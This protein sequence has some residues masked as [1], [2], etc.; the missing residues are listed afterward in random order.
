MNALYQMRYHGVAGA[1]H[2][3]I[4]IGKGQV[5]GVDITGAR[6]IGSYSDNGT[7]LDGTVTLTSSGAELVTG[8]RMAPGSKIPITFNFPANFGNGQFQTVTV[9]NASVQVAFDKI[10]DIP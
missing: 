7:S 1:G 8:L 4:Y 9:G 3:A 5:A 6:Y 10:A 2:G